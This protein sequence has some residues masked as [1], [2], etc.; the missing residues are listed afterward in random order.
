LELIREI[1]LGD[2]GHNGFMA[3][4]RVRSHLKDEIGEE[5][6]NLLRPAIVAYWEDAIDDEIQAD[7]V[8]ED[9]FDDEDV[10][11]GERLV[12]QA[13]ERILSEYDLNFRTEDVRTIARRVD[14]VSIIEGNRERAA[15]DAIE[16]DEVSGTGYG[17]DAI[18]DLFDIDTPTGS[19]T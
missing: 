11:E 7:E 2:L 6:D 18:D 4:S 12:E 5:V 8:L 9:L 14:V 15:G 13:V 19:G 10:I 3:L 16:H 1:P 17:T